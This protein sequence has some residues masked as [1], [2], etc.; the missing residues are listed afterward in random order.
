MYEFKALLSRENEDGSFSRAIEDRSTDQL[1]QNEVLIKVHFAALNYKDAL[2]ATGHKGVTREFPHTPGVDASGE[3]LSDSTGKF[4]AGDKVLVTGYDLGMNTDGGFGGYISVPSAWVVPLPKGIDLYQA[5]VMG[6]G[7]FTAG[8]AVYKMELN[9]QNPEMGAILVTGASGGVGSFAVSILA[10]AGYEVIASTGKETAHAYLKGLGATKCISREDVNIESKRPLFKSICAGAIDTVGGNT[11]STVLKSCKA[12]GNV[13]STGLVLSPFF[14]I[15][16]YPFIIK[17]INLLGIDSAETP[18]D[19]RLK[20]WKN[21]S[22]KWKP[23]NLKSIGNIVSLNELDKEVDNI[24]KG[25]TK[26]RIVV[27]HRTD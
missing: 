10:K 5:M 9:G 24:L 15:N 3:V 8:L 12:K 2:S 27:K 26:G 20:V 25:Q 4:K 7:A 17:G 23:N 22:S 11:L 18:M 19:L 16:V 14:S 21:L 6:T 13:A 1:A